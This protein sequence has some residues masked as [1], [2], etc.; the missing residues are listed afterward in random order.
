MGATGSSFIDISGTGTAIPAVGDDTEHNITI[1]GGFTFNG[2]NYTDARIGANGVIV[3]GSTTGD[4]SLTNAA[5]PTGTVAAGNAFL[6]P[7]WD[8]IDNDAGGGQIFIGQ[9]GDL[10]IAQWNNWGR[11]AA[12][13]GQVIT[14]QVQLNQVTGQIFFVYQDVIFGGTQAAANDNGL[15]ATV[16]IQWANA[17]GS[18]IQYSFNTASLTDGQVISFTPNTPSYSWTPNTYLTADNIANPMAQNVLA[19]ITYT[20]TVTAGGCSSSQ[21][22]LVEA[23]PAILPSEAEIIPDPAAF[24]TGGSVTLTAVPLGGGGPYTFTWTDPNLVV[25]TPT[26]VATQ[27]ANIAGLWSVQ[28]DD[29]C[30]GTATASIT[31]VENPTP[32]A[33][34]SASQACIGGTLQLT[35]TT[36][37]GTS[38]TWTGPNSF[39]STSQNPTVNP[40]VAASGGTYIFTATAGP[41]TSA[42]SSVVVVADISPVI[43]ATT[44]TPNPVCS[45]NDSQLNVFASV[46]GYTMGAAGATF[47]DISGTGTPVAGV[48]GDDTEGNITITGGFTF[49]G[50]NYTS[51]RVGANGALVFGAA[52]GEITNGNAALPSAANS[53]GSVFLAPFWDDLDNLSP[54]NVYT[55]QVGSLFIVQWHQWGHFSAATEG[56]VITFQIQMDQVTGAVYFVYQDV[57]FGGEQAANDAGASATVGI[58]WANSAGNFIQ[59]SFNTAS[60]TD[61]QV[62]SFTPVAVS[63]Y[64][65]TP[66]TFLSDDAIANPVAQNPTA[67]TP[68]SVLATGANGCTA[69]GNVTLTL[70]QSLD[71]HSGLLEQPVLHQCSGEQHGQ[72]P[73]G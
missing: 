7:W 32:S 73:H 67:T 62:I 59:Y 1:P 15:N 13:A 12:V 66:N 21:N 49:N 22:L 5:L 4:I 63:S 10:L 60:L 38:F 31:V 55:Q 3:F 43:S 56:E 33:S 61:G 45:G 35:G 11:S 27:S 42:S 41:C 26:N 24:C 72:R 25:G 68:Y 57:I 2:V 20:M 53:A 51:A 44:A 28:I 30:G 17:V 48:V 69:T 58:Q 71:V 40:V 19:D 47:I 52:T 54:S 39:A 29:A 14:F 37:I 34:A 9:S 46:P 64:L 16:G 50:I 23:N 70:N 65:W 18:A 8:D 6:A 36:D